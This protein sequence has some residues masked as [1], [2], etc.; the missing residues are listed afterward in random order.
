MTVLSKHTDEINMR[1]GKE[2]FTQGSW[3]RDKCRLQ[4]KTNLQTP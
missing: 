1:E 2:V 4:I 3:H